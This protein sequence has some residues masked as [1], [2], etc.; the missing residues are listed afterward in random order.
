MGDGHRPP[1]PASL[2]GHRGRAKTLEDYKIRALDAVDSVA[3]AIRR[4]FP[5]L[6]GRDAVDLSAALTSMVGTVGQIANPSRTMAR[7]HAGPPARPHRRRLPAAAHAAG[8]GLRPRAAHP[9]R[10]RRGGVGVDWS[11]HVDNPCPMRYLRV[12][13]VRSDCR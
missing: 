13:R 5:Q 6:G 4:A 1:A 9:E 11:R 10:G 7:L 2:T 3:A 12:C 8:R